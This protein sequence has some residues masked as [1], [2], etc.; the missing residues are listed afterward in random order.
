MLL[1]YDQL[2]L[3]TNTVP[4]YLS[5][6]IDKFSK[7][8]DLLEE[9][10]RTVKIAEIPADMLIDSIGH[11]KSQEYFDLYLSSQCE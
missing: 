5:G 2:D 1:L 9:Y 6:K 10:I 11:T 4:A 8:Y 7:T 3:D